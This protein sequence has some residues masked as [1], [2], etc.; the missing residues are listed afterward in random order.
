MRSIGDKQQ[1]AATRDINAVIYKKKKQ[2]LL[3]VSTKAVPLDLH[4]NTL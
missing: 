3:N 2:T 1:W 4:T